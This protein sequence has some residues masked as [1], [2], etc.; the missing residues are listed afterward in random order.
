[1]DRKAG[2]S[3]VEL[4]LP[5]SENSDYLWNS[6]CIFFFFG[7]VGNVESLRASHKELKKVLGIFLLYIRHVS[8]IYKEHLQCNKTKNLTNKNDKK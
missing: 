3:T 8:R 2:R 6:V 7:T 1:M 5:S 4:L